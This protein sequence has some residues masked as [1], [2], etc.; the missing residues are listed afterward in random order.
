V[1]KNIIISSVTFLTAILILLNRSK[2]LRVFPIIIAIIVG[3][4][5]SIILGVADISAI[6]N[7]G[8][9]KLPNFQVP[10]LTYDFKFD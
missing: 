3:F 2:Q 7:D 8:L 6:F 4:L 10:G 5:V 9:L 1:W